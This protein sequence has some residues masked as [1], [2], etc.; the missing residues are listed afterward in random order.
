MSFPY[1]DVEPGKVSPALSANARANL[2]CNILYATGSLF[3]EQIFARFESAAELRSWLDDDV[4]GR[5]AD[6]I[7][8]HFL[9]RG[10]EPHQAGHPV[11]NGFGHR[12]PDVVETLRCESRRHDD[13]SPRRFVA[14]AARSRARDNE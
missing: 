6:R 2:Q 13:E 9:T 1:N 10:Q 12:A 7:T 5:E 11:P 3:S 14:Q 8:M 4:E